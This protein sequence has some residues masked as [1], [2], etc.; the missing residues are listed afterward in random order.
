MPEMRDGIERS[1]WIDVE[2]DGVESELAWLREA[3]YAVYAVYGGAW[4][5]LPPGGIP[6]GA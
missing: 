6:H 4:G 5:Y 3:V 1:W 2:P